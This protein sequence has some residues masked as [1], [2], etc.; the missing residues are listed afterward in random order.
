MSEYPCEEQADGSWIVRVPGKKFECAIC[1]KND[2]VIAPKTVAANTSIGMIGPWWLPG[3]ENIHVPGLNDSTWACDVCA[4][5]YRE[6]KKLADRIVD[7]AKRNLAEQIAA[8]KGMPLSTDRA[9]CKAY[10]KA[11]GFSW[12]PCIRCG[13]ERAAYELNGE[14]VQCLK[15]TNT[16][17]L[18]CCE[19]VSSEDDAHAC[20]N[21]H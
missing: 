9:A 5:S 6:A 16:G 19:R 2:K 17:H 3:W 21:K 12:T 7:E 13:E 11:H 20:A 18:A 4:T 14:R 15:E 1:G 8:I 10:A